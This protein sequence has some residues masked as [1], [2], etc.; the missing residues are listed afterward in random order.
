MRSVDRA[1][2]RHQDDER[3]PGGSSTRR[4][5][6][7]S[8]RSSTAC[9]AIY[10]LATPAAPR[11]LGRGP[12]SP[13]TAALTPR[14][15]TRPRN[16][17]ALQASPEGAL[18]M[19]IGVRSIVLVA[20]TVLLVGCSRGQPNHPT[21]QPGGPAFEMHVLGG[22]GCPSPVQGSACV[23]VSV[24]NRGD[25]GDGRCRLRGFQTN[26][27]SGA[28]HDVWGSWIEL[29]QLGTGA[30]VVRITPWRVGLPAVGY[31]EPGLHS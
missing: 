15:T 28:E 27:A 30:T 18:H 7:G 4:A 17:G 10:G 21:P 26:P 24:T 1:T 11:G 12:C 2:T 9:D 14:T 29:S 22:V 19:T 16:H 8:A 20:T 13:H 31:C 5:H 3:L 25:P 23:R 6:R